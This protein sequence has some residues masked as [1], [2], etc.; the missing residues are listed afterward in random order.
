MNDN[1][2]PKCGGEIEKRYIQLSQ[3]D[4]PEDEIEGIH[5]SW[6]AN[7]HIGRLLDPCDDCENHL[8]GDC[9][10]HDDSDCAVYEIFIL[11]DELIHSKTM[12][13]VSR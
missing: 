4:T 8:N 13:E 1:K 5:T 6:C 12:G 9:P 11:Q 2:C 3:E 10:G 7:C